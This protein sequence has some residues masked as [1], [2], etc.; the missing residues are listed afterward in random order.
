MLT[1]VNAMTLR[2]FVASQIGGLAKPA[3][4]RAD[5]AILPMRLVFVTVAAVAALATQ[6]VMQ[7]GAALRGP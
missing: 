7:H 5:S 2:G 6:Y 1:T 4:G 3:Q